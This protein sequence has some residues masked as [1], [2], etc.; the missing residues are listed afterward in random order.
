MVV[1]AVDPG[2][3]GQ[4]GQDVGAAVG[5]GGQ[6]TGV[7]GRP[8]LVIAGPGQRP[9]VEGGVVAE[10]AGRYVAEHLAVEPVE[11]AQPPRLPVAGIGDPAHH[12]RAHLPAAADLLHPG[13]V[14]GG[15]D[16]QHPLLALGGH[17]LVGGHARLAPGHGRHVDVHAHAAAGRGLAG[18]TDQAGPAQVLDAHH[19]LGV[20]QLEARLD[21]PLL[22]VGVAHLHA[23]PLG[24]LGLGVPAPEAG[25]GQ[26]A[27]PT[28]AVPT[29]RRPEQHGQVAHPGGR[30]EHQSLGGQ[31]PHAQH[32]DQRVLG[33]AVVEGQLPADGGHPHRVAVARDA[34]HHPFDEPL[35]PGL[36]GVPEEQRVHHGDGSGPHGEDVPQDAAHPGGRPLVG[37]DGRG[38]VVALDPDGHGDAVAGIDDAGVLPRA[39]QH[40]GAL[41]GQPLQVDP[42]RLVRAVLAP[43]DGE[44]GQ[45]EVV[46]RAAEDG[47]HLVPLPVGEAEGPVQRLSG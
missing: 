43:H 47:L 10:G 38:M 37:L 15:D 44:Q 23:R 12:G 24:R 39:H 36:G 13:Q 8:G 5:R 41:G 25:R 45:L 14:L 32:V 40:M 31:H 2:R 29:G 35:L 11:D 17:D 34:G 42:R 16:G 33:V 19:Q 1:L 20:E 27:D 30:P 46:R 18:G 3:V 4:H 26:H 22:L 9:V 6:S 28:D 21:Q 7:V